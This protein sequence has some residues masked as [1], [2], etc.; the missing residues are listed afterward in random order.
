MLLSMLTKPALY[1]AVNLETY[2]TVL[3]CVAGLQNKEN[4]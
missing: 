3:E 1:P 4:S 2:K